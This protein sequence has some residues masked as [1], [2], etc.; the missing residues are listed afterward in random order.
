[1]DRDDILVFL[2]G[3]EEIEAMVKNVKDIANDLPLGMPLT[4]INLLIIRH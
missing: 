2:T 4:V 1:M 3:Q